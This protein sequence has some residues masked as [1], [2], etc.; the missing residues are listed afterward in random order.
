MV[1]LIEFI[2]PCSPRNISGVTVKW[3]FEGVKSGYMMSPV[4][5]VSLIKNPEMKETVFQF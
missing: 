2:F 4:N 5:N 1:H 3:Y